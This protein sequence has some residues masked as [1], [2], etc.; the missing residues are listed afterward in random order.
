MIKCDPVTRFF[1]TH[2]I[3]DHNRVYDYDYM[4]EENTRRNRSLRNTEVGNKRKMNHTEIIMSIQ[5][6]ELHEKEEEE[7]EDDEKKINPK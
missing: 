7:D 5:I 2:Y 6:Q 1:F 4:Y 3:H